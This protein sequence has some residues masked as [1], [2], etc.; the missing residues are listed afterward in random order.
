LLDIS[1]PNRKDNKMD[2]TKHLL[3]IV[4]L[5]FIIILSFSSISYSAEENLVGVGYG[6]VYTAGTKET[7]QNYRTNQ[8]E[9]VTSIKNILENASNTNKLPFKLLFETDAEGNKRNLSANYDIYSLAVVITRDDIYNEKFEDKETNTA[10][11]KTYI[12]VGMV[13]ILYQ[14]LDDPND[15]GKKKNSIIFSL[16]IVGYSIILSGKAELSSN[17]LDNEFVKIIEKTLEEE[18]V[19]RLQN[20]SIGKLEG[21]VIRIEKDK[22]IIDLGSSNGIFEGNRI[23]LDA[24]HKVA[25]GNVK[26]VSL[27]E[28]SV[29]LDTKSE[30]I[31]EGTIVQCTNIKG[32]SDETY[33]VVDFKISSEKFKKLFDTKIISS[34]AS[35]W[36]SDFLS[37]RGGKLVF[38]SKVGNAWTE[39]STESSCTLFGVDGRAHLFDVPKPEYP[40]ILDITGIASKKIEEASNN[41]N[42]NWIYKLWLKVEIPEK[43]YAK[44]FSMNSTKSII[45]GMQTFEEK[46]E[47]F[48]L[49]HQL[50]AKAAR[51]FGE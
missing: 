42:E 31:K 32:L 14:T 8:K 39:R 46:N 18:L 22:I 3:K 26:E 35:Q 23:Y 12:N 20:I 7:F 51:E 11:V 1:C 15:A 2:C 9:V 4:S 30:K 34:Q 28:S 13:I 10:I 29:P 33:Q 45:V 36:F 43:K 40:I 47:F 5:M 48:E 37:D 50:T 17:D 25:I 6:G 21:K 19:K 16:P 27:H 38:P 41:I 24:D 49:L 44:E